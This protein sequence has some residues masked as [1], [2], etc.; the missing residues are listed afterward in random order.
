MSQS[1]PIYLPLKPNWANANKHVF[2]VDLCHSRRLCVMCRGEG[3]CHGGGRVTRG[4][5][6]QAAQDR[7]APGAKLGAY[8]LFEQRH[9][10]HQFLEKGF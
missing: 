5:A 3:D 9:R 7:Q 8:L 2:Q 1:L 6:D 10:T 4:L